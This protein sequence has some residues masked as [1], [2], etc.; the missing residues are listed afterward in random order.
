MEKSKVYFTNMQATGK[1]NLLQKLKR[2]IKS[3]GIDQ[4]DFEKNTQQ[5]RSISVSQVMWHFYAQIL[6]KL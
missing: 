6:L 2:L 3:S 5:L 4:I 1:E